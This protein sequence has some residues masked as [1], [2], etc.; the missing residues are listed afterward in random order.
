[1]RNTKANLELIEV[2]LDALIQGEVK[3]S[4]HLSVKVVEMKGNNVK[5][6]HDWLLPSTEKAEP[7]QTPVASEPPP[8][9]VRRQFTV[10]GIF[11]DPQFVRVMKSLAVSDAKLEVLKPNP[12]PQMYVLPA[13]MGGQ[14]MKVEPVIGPDGYTIELTIRTPSQDQ[15]PASG[16]ST[17]IT[18]WDGQTVVL[19][20]QP[21][22]GV[23]RLL[24]IT[25][26]LI[27][28]REQKVK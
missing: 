8:L 6:L 12:K 26:S 25:G 7:I 24:F 11:T 28:V 4:V 9:A 23:S 5:Q 1:M 15:N 3:K 19:G 22:E 17:A 21:S 16:I 10:S 2:W 27:E 14:E 13:A 18:I 20:S